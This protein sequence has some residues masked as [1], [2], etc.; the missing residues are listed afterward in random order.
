MSPSVHGGDR[1]QSLFGAMMPHPG[2]PGRARRIR[3]KVS[4]VAML[5][6]LAY[7]ISDL[8][9]RGLAMPVVVVVVVALAVFAAAWLRTM[10]LSLATTAPLRRIAPWLVVAGTV[11]VPLAFGVGTPGFVG[12]FIYLSIAAAVSLPLGATAPAIVTAT[13]CAALL[14]WRMPVRVSVDAAFGQLSYVFW[15]GMMMAFYRRMMLLV[16]E[17]RQAREDLARLAVTEER[18]RFARDLHDLLGH[19]LSTISLKAQLA[20]RL[21][22]GDPSTVA[23]IADIESVAQQALTEVREAVTGYRLTSSA[24]EL[25]S[26]RTALAAAG[27]E[28]VIRWEAVT[29][30]ARTDALLGWVLREAV[31][32][33]VRHSDA[34]A[35]AIALTRRD[36][37]LVLD[38][39]N[40]G[41]AP[42]AAAPTP[43][44]GVLGMTERMESAG[45]LL[46]AGVEPEGGFRLVATLPLDELTLTQHADR[47]VPDPLAAHGGVR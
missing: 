15:L 18:L 44:N 26:A 43:G 30:T 5:G 47:S 9:H 38:V 22:A 29:M 10:W 3:W 24:L 28:V 27:I 17:L 39:R 1:S 16:I 7:P 8:Q 31:T 35:C 42:P 14:L 46:R 20:R 21:A 37:A 41:V 6:F 4:Q 23:E 33:V 11:G 34:R 13:A 40:D 2:P 19:S 36:G 45:G 12:L 25:E 32:N